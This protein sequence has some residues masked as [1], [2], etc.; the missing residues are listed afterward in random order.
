[1]TTS[2]DAEQLA[3]DR[4]RMVERDLR[5]EGIRDERVLAAMGSVPRHEFVPPSLRARAY[6]DAPL[7]IGEGQTI[8]QPFVVAL[9]TEHLATRPGMRVLEV[10]TGSGYQAAVLAELGCEV[11]SIE[12]LPDLA[13]Q[14]RE[15]L[16]RLGYR[17]HVR[18][19][20]GFY[21]W[22]EE[23]PFDAIVITAASPEVPET[24]VAQLR[25]GGRIILPLGKGSGQELTLGIKTPTGVDLRPLGGVAFVPMTGK[26]RE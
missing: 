15:R 9:M 11:Y 8:S 2:D 16:E 23:A 13:D 1:V 26:V 22:P 24:L 20:D 7:P 4:R 3:Q 21:G 17:V 18:A 14:A 19:G 5:G 12:I 10:G 25:Q 6:A